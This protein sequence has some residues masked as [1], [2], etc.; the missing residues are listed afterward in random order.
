[1]TVPFE[2]RSAL[3]TCR[4]TLTI[5]VDDENLTAVARGTAQWLLHQYPSDEQLDAVV[6]A[7]TGPLP[8]SAAVLSAT[9][10]LFAVLVEGD[11]GSERT[12]QALHAALR[13]HPTE[14]RV[15]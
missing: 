12:K 2:Q 14:G 1:M 4:Q 8:Q 3:K 13:H 10:T 11:Q 5:I 9:A 7:K 6:I 15:L